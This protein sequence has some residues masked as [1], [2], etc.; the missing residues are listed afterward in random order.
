VDVDIYFS[1]FTRFDSEGPG[2]IFDNAEGSLGTFPHY[3]AKLP[4]ENQ[5]AASRSA[6]RFD[7]QNVATR[8]CLGK[9]GRNAGHARAHGQLALE[10][11]RTENGD[12]IFL[13]NMNWSGKSFRNKH[14][15][16]AQG[17]ADL[18]FEVSNTSLPGV[19]PDNLAQRFLSNIDLT[20]LNSFA[21]ICRGTR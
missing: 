14:G 3:F 8:R 19:M 18:T 2:A 1:E 17:L 15:S 13:A 5:L 9:A 4:G 21:A 6:S 16:M 7:E 12:K 11:P 10:R 20:G